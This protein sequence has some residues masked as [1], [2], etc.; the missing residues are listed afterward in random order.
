MQANANTIT[1]LPKKYD[2]GLCERLVDR[3]DIGTAG[4]RKTLLLLHALYRRFGNSGLIAQLLGGPTKIAASHPDLGTDGTR[5][6]A[7]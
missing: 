3:L 2:P 7:D 4:D 5:C 1:V 6:Q